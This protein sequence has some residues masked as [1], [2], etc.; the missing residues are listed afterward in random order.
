MFSITCDGANGTSY[1][2][3]DKAYAA[4]VIMSICSCSLSIIGS[5]MIFGSYI[6]IPE[7]RNSTRKLV[8]CLT[9]AD[10]LTA[11]GYLV[12]AVAYFLCN[13]H[14]VC[15]EQSIITTYS[16]LVS[17]YLTMA[18][19]VHIFTTVVFRKDSTSSLKFF[20]CVNII[21]WVVPGIIVGVAYAQDVLGRDDSSEKGSTGTPWCWLKHLH[22]NYQLWVFLSGKGW[23]FLCYLITTSAYVLLKWNRR[24]NHNR[25]RFN[26]V[27]DS[28][29]DEDRNYLYVWLFIY[30][31]R[32]WGSVRSL[33]SF[34][35]NY[36]DNVIYDILVHMQAIGDP[37]QAFCNFILFCVFDKTV[38]DHVLR[39]CCNPCRTSNTPEERTP[40][41]QSESSDTDPKGFQSSCV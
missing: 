20:I 8:T 11:V 31:L 1:K 2:L 26:V 9:V 41:R 15:E 4:A 30:I 7:I 10:F 33:M 18:I 27:H 25:E 3:N 22:N 29:R 6:F 12:S 16:S 17:F 40:L 35:E 24:L 5:F 39:A 21:C 38:R 36:K 32:L 19:A 34:Q 13:L 37:G 14:D 28:L 23:E